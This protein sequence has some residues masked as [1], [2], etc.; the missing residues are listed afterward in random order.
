MFILKE[1]VIM[2]EGVITQGLFEYKLTKK[3]KTKKCHAYEVTS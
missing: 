1:M 3:M 2:T